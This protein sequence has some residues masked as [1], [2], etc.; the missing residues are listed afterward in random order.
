MQFVQVFAVIFALTA[1][2]PSVNSELAALQSEVRQ[3]RATVNMLKKQVQAL[4]QLQKADRLRSG[5]EP[6]LLPDVLGIGKK[7]KQ[8]DHLNY[9]LSTPRPKEQMISRLRFEVRSV[10]VK[11]VP[12]QSKQKV[13]IELKISNYDGES[14]STRGFRY[15]LQDKNRLFLANGQASFPITLGHKKSSILRIKFYITEPLVGDAAYFV[16][17][18]EDAGIKAAARCKIPIKRVLD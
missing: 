9:T 6:I 13:T 8:K 7:N 2:A 3:L 4:I 14:R 5:R 12:Y 1:P 18:L 10:D 16:V 15:L 11:Q 17:D